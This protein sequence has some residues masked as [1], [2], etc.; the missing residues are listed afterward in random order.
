MKLLAR[1][2]RMRGPSRSTAGSGIFL[3]AVLVLG[4]RPAAAQAPALPLS[5]PTPAERAGY[6]AFTDPEQVGPYLGELAAGA[7]GLTVDSLP[8]PVAIPIARISRTAESA[9]SGDSVLRVLVVGAQHGTERAGLEVALRLARDLTAGRLAAL[10]RRLEV[11]IVPMANPWGVERG[12]RATADGVDLDRDHIRLAAP[13]TRALWSE[14][15]AWRPH[16]VLDLHEIGP[17]EYPVQIGVATHPNASGAA[18]FARFYLLPFA[19]NELARKDV[20]FHEYVAEWRDGR[21]VEGAASPA[22]PAAETVTWFTPPPLAPSSARNAFALAGSVTFFVAVS[23]SRDIIGLEQRAERLH[24]A[25]RALLTAAAG[26]APDLLATHEAARALPKGP[27][28]LSARYV[29][30][31]STAAMPWIFINDRGQR[32]QG[33]LAPWRSEVEIGAELEA[34]A[35]WWIG[36]DEAELVEAVRAHGFEIRDAGPADAAFAYPSCAPAGRTAAAAW[37]GP[38]AVAVPPPEGAVWVEADQPGGRLLFTMVEPWSDGGWFIDERLPSADT[39]AAR[40][41][42]SAATPSPDTAA[43]RAG[44]SVAACDAAGPFPVYRVTR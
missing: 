15:A 20:P 34:P 37:P 22:P 26:L 29:A 1:R 18:R 44:A 4:P 8:G 24:L 42:D 3:A 27:L 13:E 41:Q 33:R 32:G 6:L 9:G 38:D 21:H 17:S 12:R 25:V 11:R 28:T 5:Y 43:A 7:E 30:R 39:A 16:L 10:R 35:G 14:Y 19:A 2:D 40:A 31:D 36:P 23:S